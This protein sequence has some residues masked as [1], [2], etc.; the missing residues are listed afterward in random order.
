MQDEDFLPVLTAKEKRYRDKVQSLI[1]YCSYCQPYDDGEVVWIMGDR[2]ELCELLYECNVPEKVWDKLVKR[3]HCS[4]CGNSSFDLC[5]EIGMKD[6]FEKEVEENV[7]K[8]NKLYGNEVRELEQL[9]ESYPLLAYKHKFAKKIYEEIK[10]NKLPIITVQGTY[11]RARKVES[12]EVI[13]TKK[14]CNP[15]L[16]KSTEGRFNHAGQ[17]HLYLANEKIT[18]IKEVASNEESILVWCQKYELSESINDIID[19]SFDWAKLTPSTSTLLISLKMNNAISRYDRNKDNWKPDY[20]LTRY[21]MDC[22][23]SLGFNGI[24]YNSIKDEY[25]YDLVLFYP[26]RVKVKH[27]GNPCIEIFSNMEQKETFPEN[28]VDL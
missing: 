13:T 26:D 10:G 5:S 28:I 15:P 23:K 19:L 18:A 17:S 22:A 6:K 27:I 11:Y 3:L 21:I 9:L 8:A 12:S 14:M 1:E 2:I 25:S 16:G 4:H 20:C 24:K 7:N